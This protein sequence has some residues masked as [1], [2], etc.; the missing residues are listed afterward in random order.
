MWVSQSPWSK[1]SARL[2]CF[3]VVVVVTVVIFTPVAAVVK[4]DVD[5]VNECRVV[6]LI[7]VSP[8]WFMVRELCP[9]RTRRTTDMEL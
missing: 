4:E 5:D 6:L 3:G 1:L 7:L 9:R 2:G 8:F